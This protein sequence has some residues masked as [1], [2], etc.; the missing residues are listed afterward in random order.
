MLRRLLLSCVLLVAGTLAH[1]ADWPSRPLRI[2]VAAPGGSS[3]DLI[4]RA[5]GD[6]L[7]E[8]FGQP[9]I[10]DNQP[11][12][13]GTIASAQVVRAAA[14]GHTLLL[15]FNGPLAYTQFLTRLP[16]DP[17]QDL[18]PVIQT[19]AQPNVL[20]VSAGLPVRT[21]A[22]LIRHAKSRPGRLNYASVGNGSSSHLTMELFKSMTGAF[23]VHIPY[24]GA[25]PAAMSV[26]AGETQA[27]F[28]VPAAVMPQIRAGKLRALAVSSAS[29]FPL[30]PDL[31]TVAESGLPG[32]EAIT[33]N[34]LLV[35]RGTPAE[36]VHR[37][38]Q[39]INAILRLPDVAERL[40]RAG[41]MPTGGS[42]A[43]FASLIASDA[44]KWAAVIRRTGATLD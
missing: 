41:L 23:I 33:W 37:I 1:G 31:P 8:R 16:Y 10:V 7:R 44:R 4:A 26:A 12:A 43:E 30:L 19:S 22:E 15:S 11:G 42:P 2:V 28:S 38:N 3:L 13:S 40:Q 24:N 25:P 35:P 17:Q 34:G 32:F 27:L 20:V 18:V 21:V 36:T 5:I 39:E 6:H 9:V 29:R 14:D